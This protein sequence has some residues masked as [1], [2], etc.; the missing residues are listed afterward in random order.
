MTQF[1]VLGRDG[2]IRNAMEIDLN[3]INSPDPLAYAYGFAVGSRGEA[4]GSKRGKAPEYIRG[5]NDGHRKFME[6]GGI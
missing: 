6:S 5:W 4:M 1:G 2:N 3:S